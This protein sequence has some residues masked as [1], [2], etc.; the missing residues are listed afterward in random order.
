MKKFAVAAF[1]AALLAMGGG[2]SAQSFTF[3]VVWTP[4]ENVG[5]M[6]GP[7]GSQYGGGAV[8]GT[9]TTTYADGTKTTGSARCVG[10]SQP[11]GSIFA[12]HMACTTTEAGGSA[13]VVYGCNYIGEPGPETPLGCVGGIEGKAGEYAA[14]RGALTM[15]W[16]SETG[17]RGTGQ[18]YG[19]K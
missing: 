8:S 7:E 3:E 10:M 15:E 17:S 5:G 19:S 16:Y 4:V 14:R 12:I 11:H 9:Y 18:W 1:G 2:V 13:S 6:T